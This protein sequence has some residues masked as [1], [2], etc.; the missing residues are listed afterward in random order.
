MYT[1]AADAVAC[2]TPAR[3]TINPQQAPCDA[4]TFIK[5]IQYHN[6][7][8]PLLSRLTEKWSEGTIWATLGLR[9]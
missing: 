9:L 8:F 2:S 7:L 4:L 1:A 3:I 6:T 5:L